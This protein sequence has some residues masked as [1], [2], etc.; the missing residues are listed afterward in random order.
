M[1][2]VNFYSKPESYNILF[3]SS[4]TLGKSMHTLLA[5]EYKLQKW[6]YSHWE[7]QNNQN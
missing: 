3:K 1:F 6:K 2:L 4:S 7:K 5:V